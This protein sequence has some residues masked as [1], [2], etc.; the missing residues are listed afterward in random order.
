MGNRKSLGKKVRFEVFKRDQFTC[1]Y[2]GQ[3]PPAVILEVDHIVP[4]CEGG[5][6]EQENLITA[7]FDCNRGKG[8]TSLKEAPAALAEQMQQNKE[9]VQQ[10]AAYNEFLKEK[11]EAVER[12]IEALGR[13]WN[14]QICPEDE[15]GE[16]VFGSA[17]QTSVRTFLKHLPAEEIREAI[18]MAIARF[19]WT[20]IDNDDRAWK[21]FCAICWNK[22]RG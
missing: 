11:R 9:K 3:S 12:D 21:Y 13:R 22:I 10:V 20:S 19:H 7:C 5:E 14:D 15:V 4:V 2:C 16:W 18:D 8:G 1:Q 6:N 17:R